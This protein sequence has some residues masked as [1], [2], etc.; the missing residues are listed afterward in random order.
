MP[1]VGHEGLNLGAAIGQDL[2]YS[3]LRGYTAQA[4]VAI[5]RIGHDIGYACNR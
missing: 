5:F 4:I 3:L 2:V 1:A